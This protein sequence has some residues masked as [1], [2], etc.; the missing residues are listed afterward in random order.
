MVDFEVSFRSMFCCRHQSRFSFSYL[1]IYG[2]PF[3]HL[4]IEFPVSCANSC[5]T[6]SK[7]NR[8]TSCVKVFFSSNTAPFF[9]KLTFGDCVQRVPFLLHQSIA[10]VS[11]MPLD[12]ALHTSDLH[13][14][15]KVA[16]KV[17]IILPCR[18]FLFK[19]CFRIFVLAKPSCRS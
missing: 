5:H 4:P 6:T 18:S 10:L 7:H 2:N 8:S 13:F 19:Q 15:D 14:C 3:F 17:L 1:T 9:S 11:K 16:D 12:I